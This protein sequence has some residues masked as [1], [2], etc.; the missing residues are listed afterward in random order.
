ME[1]RHLDYFLMV[2]ETGSLNAAAKKLYIS[3]QALSKNMDTI[4]QELGQALFIRSPKGLQ[5]TDAGHILRGEAREILRQHDHMIDR[6]NHLKS[7]KPD[8][9][10]LSFYSGLF[11]QLGNNYMQN[12]ILSHPDVQVQLFSYLDVSQ[13][14]DNAN[15]DVDLFFSTNRLAGS[16]LDL[17]YEYHTPLCALMS[18]NHRLA[19]CSELCLDDLQN[20]AVIT[21]NADYDT[22]NLLALQLERHNVT[23]DFCLGDTESDLIYWLVLNQDAVSFFAGPEAYLPQGTVKKPIKDLLVPWNFFIYGKRNR[24]SPIAEDMIESVKA[25]RESGEQS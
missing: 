25:I 14:R 24:L 16:S 23:V 11:Y 19:S 15:Y 20:E 10:K 12:F 4:E 18:E 2:C 7:G 13:A 17:L 8:I 22:K 6:M 21:L 5:L 3:Q 1:L 9:L